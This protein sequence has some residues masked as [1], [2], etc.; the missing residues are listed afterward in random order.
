MALGAP[1]K[2]I[3]QLV[4][5]STAVM[6][7]IGILLGVGLS[8]ALSKTVAAWAGGGSPRDPLTLFGAALLLMLVSAIACLVPAWRAATV[9][10][11][12]ALRYE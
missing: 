3:L 1:R 8:I 2:V 9:N 5:K 7:G 4:M 11:V 12:V 10:P 6:L